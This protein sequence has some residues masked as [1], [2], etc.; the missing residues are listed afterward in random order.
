LSPADSALFL[1]FLGLF[2][3]HIAEF[4]RIEDF[5]AL[6]ALYILGVLFARYYAHFGMFTGGVHG[7]FLAQN[8]GGIVQDCIGWHLPVNLN[9]QICGFST[10]MAEWSR[11]MT[12]VGAL[13]A[14][15]QLFI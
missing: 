14:A 10:P 7:W 3:G 4:I 5:A 6:Q 12:S 8:S 11:Q 2:D 15:C 9:L 13:G 1:D